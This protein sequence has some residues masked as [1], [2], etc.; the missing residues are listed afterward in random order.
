MKAVPTLNEQIEACTLCPRLVAYRQQVAQEK[1]RAYSDWNYWGRPVPNFGPSPAQVLIVGLAPAA[2]G[3]NRTGRMFTGD[4]SGEWLYRALHKA[5]FANQATSIDVEDGLKLIH[6]AIT[7]TCH[8][9]P[10]DNKP[11]PSEIANCRRWLVSTIEL[12]NPSVFVALGQLAY[13]AVLAEARRN[14]WLTATP[15]RFAHGQCV[16]LSGNRWLVASFHPSQQNTFT[17]KLTEPMFDAIF[18]Q[19]RRLLGQPAPVRKVKR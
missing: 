2:H 19:V 15:P 13:K 11:L 12:Q 7:A 16:P 18:A 10:P 3:A 5:G 9:A 8:C 14:N 4:R 1:R 6:C 17:G